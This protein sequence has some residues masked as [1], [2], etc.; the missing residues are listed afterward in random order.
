VLC[1]RPP[2]NHIAGWLGTRRTVPAFKRARGYPFPARWTPVPLVRQFLGTGVPPIPASLASVADKSLPRKTW[3]RRRA[4]ARPRPVGWASTLGRSRS[5]VEVAV[6]LRFNPI[7]TWSG[8]RVA[9][10]G[11]STAREH[12]PSPARSRVN[13]GPISLPRCGP[14]FLLFLPSSTCH[15][16]VATAPSCGMWRV[17]GAERRQTR[18]AVRTRT[19]DRG[20]KPATVTFPLCQELDAQFH[21]EGPR[22]VG[23]PCVP[24]S[25]ST[26]PLSPR[27]GAGARI[28]RLG[29]SF[30]L[31]PGNGG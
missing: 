24:G 17:R 9:F 4:M 31:P 5:Y 1:G 29:L 3:H 13:P 15:R 7:A 19:G 10:D 21:V 26:T 8:T 11:L 16:T 12:S 14:G 22:A 25:Q 23:G 18:A 2:V 27:Q 20:A 6:A 28:L 30:G